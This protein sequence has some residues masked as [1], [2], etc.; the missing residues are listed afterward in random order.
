MVHITDKPPSY[1]QQN[2]ERIIRNTVERRRLVMNSDKYINAN[3]QKLIDDLN[4]GKQK[5]ITEA[6][7]NKYFLARNPK[8]L[9][10]YYD[11]F[12]ENE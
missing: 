11:P 10:Y 4:S 8:T 7:K 1:Y 6:M 3:R 5:F 2:R 12:L 9:E